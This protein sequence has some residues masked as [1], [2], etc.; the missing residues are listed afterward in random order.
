M[1]DPIEKI[2][3]VSFDFDLMSGKTTREH[4]SFIY[5]DEELDCEHFQNMDGSGCI[6]CCKGNEPYSCHRS[7][8][9]GLCHKEVKK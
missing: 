8:K 9:E 2:P 4:K 6:N 3:V 7:K 5:K 1:N